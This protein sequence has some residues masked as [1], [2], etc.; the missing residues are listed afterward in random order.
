MPEYRCCAIDTDHNVVAVEVVR[1]RNDEFA[2]LRAAIILANFAVAGVEA[3]EGER[4]VC[5]LWK[6][7]IVAEDR[8]VPDAPQTAPTG[9]ACSGCGVRITRSPDWPLANDTLICPDCG[10]STVVR[11]YEAQA[12]ARAP[13]E[14]PAGMSGGTKGG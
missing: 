8:T 14:R 6:P 1:Y 5:R 11:R 4:L 12:A 9:M 13:V 10:K 7:A 2:R 3:W